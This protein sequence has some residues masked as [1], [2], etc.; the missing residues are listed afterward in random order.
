MPRNPDSPRQ[1]VVLVEDNEDLRRGLAEYLSLC[2]FVV[3]EAATGAA[4]FAA[5]QQN[6]YDVVILDVNLPDVSG[7][8]LA[9]FMAAKGD[10]GIIVLTARG[11]RQDRVRGYETGADLYLTKPVD[12]EELAL[13]AWNL[14]L[15]VR[16]MR[17]VASQTQDKAETVPP[18][19]YTAPEPALPAAKTGGWV[20]DRA[21]QALHCPNG[22]TLAVSG[23][24][25]LLLE[26]MAG[27]VGKII[28]RNS[29]QSIYEEDFVPVES[30]K[31]DVAISRLRIKIRS[32][33]TELPVQIIRGG[34]IRLLEPIIIT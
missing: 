33:G 16:R 3:D 1:R 7:F 30:R 17:G 28:S 20:L 2:N 6:R 5:L 31:L 21:R 29:L 4:F 10:A 13:A 9:R 25:S 11:S 22:A 34:G 26:Q 18:L 12:S 24:E 8:D 27:Q 32:A 23:K 15:R 14:G 19:P